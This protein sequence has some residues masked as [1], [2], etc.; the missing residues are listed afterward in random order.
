MK[1]EYVWTDIQELSFK[2]NLKEY[3]ELNIQTKYNYSVFYSDD[4][5]RCIGVLD[6]ELSPVESEGELLVRY[7]SRSLFNL[8]DAVLTDAV[9]KELHIETYS[10]IFPLCHS[11]IKNFLTMVGLPD[12]PIKPIDYSDPNIGL[13]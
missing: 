11:H 1:L 8:K 7:H 12:I 13:R 3:A 2:K 9:K 10:W 6:I 4:G 5:S